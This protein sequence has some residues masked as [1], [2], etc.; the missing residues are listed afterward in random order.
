MAA[1]ALIA[2]LRMHGVVD[3]IEGGY[4]VVEWEGAALGDIPVA[5]LP[6]DVGEGD[7]VVLRLRRGPARDVLLPT[8]S[9]VIELPEELLPRGVRAVVTRPRREARS[10]Q[11][12]GRDVANA[13]DRG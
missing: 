7:K 8:A 13:D 2:G 4:A 1:L 9:G 3:R 5:L 11:K 12:R 6:A 10:N